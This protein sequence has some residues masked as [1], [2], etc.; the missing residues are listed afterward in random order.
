MNIAE[1]QPAGP[2][3]VTKEEMDAM[4]EQQL[5]Q[6]QAEAV[7]LQRVEALSASIF[8]RMV[9][10]S[11]IINQVCTVDEA[12][13]KIT[14][15]EPVLKQFLAIANHVSAEAATAHARQIWGIDVGRA[16]QNPQQPNAAPQQ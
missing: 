16:S 1:P 11:D 12:E 13:G 7:K 4:R 9:G 8:T 3:P 2:A 10:G 5:M 6:Q 14:I 15:N